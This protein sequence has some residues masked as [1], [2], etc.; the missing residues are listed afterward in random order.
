MA[1]FPTWIRSNLRT[2]DKFADV[3]ELLGRLRLNTVCVS[4]RC[5]NRTACWNSGTATFLLLGRVC[6]RGCPFCAVT[7]GV[8]EPVDPS[9]P[10]RVAQAV[11]AMN[12]RHVVL[13]SV[14]R[15]DLPDGGAA[16]L[17]DTIRALRAE[18]PRVSVEVLTPDFGGSEEAVATVVEARPEVFAHNL[19]TVRRLTPHV[20]RGASYDRSLNVLRWAAKMGH[21]VVKSGIMLGLGENAA[22]VREALGDLLEAGVGWVTLGQ[23]LSPSPQHYPV[24]RFVTPEEFQEWADWARRLGFAAVLAGPLVRSSYRAASVMD[25]LREN[26]SCRAF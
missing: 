17:A 20:R 23:Y 12:L 21:S 4:A 9:E 1:R 25:Q 18:C 24:Q 11:R 19:E 7:P 26:A 8:P 15:D 6:T 22:E 13:T 16:H 10:A 2:D 14:T 3:S 5:P